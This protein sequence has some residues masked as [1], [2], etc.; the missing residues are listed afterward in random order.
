RFIDLADVFNFERRSDGRIEREGA[1]PAWLTPGQDLV[2]Q[3]AGLLQQATGTRFGAQI[4]YTKNIPAGAGLGGGS[5]DAATALIA[6]NRWWQTGLDRPALLALAA[7]LGSDVPVF[8]HGDSAFAQGTGD[9]LE[10]IRLPAA[11]YVLVLPQATVSTGQIFSR[12]DLT[13]N[14]K[15]IT[16]TDFTKWQEQQ[17]SGSPSAWFGRNDLQPAA[18]A[19]HPDLSQTAAWLHEQGISSR[20]TGSGSC[21]FVQCA[22]ASEADVL[23]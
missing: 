6:L 22:T 10:S 21:F 13:R 12:P 15:P 19:S 23:K 3:A 8:I 5:S 11:S 1:V 18:C 9:L 17:V 20:M 14:T 2:V 4:Q 16:I 7:Q